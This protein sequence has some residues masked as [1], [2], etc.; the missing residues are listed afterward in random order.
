MGIYDNVDHSL[1]SSSEVEWLQPYAAAPSRTSP[2]LVQ[3]PGDVTRWPLFSEFLNSSPSPLK[4]MVEGESKELVHGVRHAV[5]LN[6]TVLSDLRGGVRSR[7]EVNK[8]TIL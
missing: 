2:R 8:K 3:R 1:P 5:S 4:L 6:S 7:T